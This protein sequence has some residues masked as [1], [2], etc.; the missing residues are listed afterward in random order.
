MTWEEGKEEEGE[1]EERGENMW[2]EFNYIFRVGTGE[3]L[4]EQNSG[5][6]WY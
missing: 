2:R 1:G 6:N 4:E 5:I 3:T